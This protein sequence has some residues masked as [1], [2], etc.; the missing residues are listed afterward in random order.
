MTSGRGP[1]S[2]AGGQATRACRYF[3]PFAHAYAIRETL[4]SAAAHLPGAHLQRTA[5][6]NGTHKL[7]KVGRACCS[8]SRS[9]RVRASAPI[10]KAGTYDELVAELIQFLEG[11]TQTRWC[12]GS[13]AEMREAARRRSS[14]SGRPACATAW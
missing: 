14:S 12:T 7:G 3:G 8:T 9:A 5:S 13:N 11:D 4:D 6:S 10:D 1:W 2:D